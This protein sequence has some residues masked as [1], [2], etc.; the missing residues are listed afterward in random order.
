LHA[1]L[2]WA[3]TENFVVLLSAAK[4]GLSRS[5]N[6]GSDLV[7]ASGAEMYALSWLMGFP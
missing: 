1:S 3:A 5:Y 4:Y 6:V 7:D 2:N